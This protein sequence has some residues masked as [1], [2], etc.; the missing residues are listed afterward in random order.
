MI[1]KAP[2]PRVAQV[3]PQVPPARAA[4]ALVEAHGAARGSPLWTTW[5]TRS[6]NH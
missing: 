1:T 5:T 4:L 3:G 2:P 6:R